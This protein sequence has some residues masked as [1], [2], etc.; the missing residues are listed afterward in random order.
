MVSQADE[1]A[2]PASRESLPFCHVS[3][4]P[5]AGLKGIRRGAPGSHVTPVGR[6]PTWV[7]NIPPPNL[8]HSSTLLGN[9]RGFGVHRFVVDSE[10]GRQ[11]WPRNGWSLDTW[12]T[13]V[14][15]DGTS[16]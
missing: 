14:G 3:V 11:R 13:S 16:S 8:V 5:A 4:A 7:R 6:P 10:E 9:Q 12:C 1:G 15:R 2:F